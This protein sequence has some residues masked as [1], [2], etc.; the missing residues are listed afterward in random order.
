M[1]QWVQ[2]LREKIFLKILQ[3]VHRRPEDTA[4]MDPNMRVTSIGILFDGTYP[5][6][7]Q[8]LDQLV[9][10]LRQSNNQVLVLGYIDNYSIASTYPFKHFYK[11][12][13]NWLYVPKHP[14]INQF[15]RIRCDILLNLGRPDLL[16]LHYIAKQAMASF[17]VGPHYPGIEIYDVMVHAPNEHTLDGFIANVKRLLKNIQYRND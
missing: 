15:T 13:V 8:V 5:E 2:H 16:P 14:D 1:M 7:R 12:H 10:Q 3:N 17:K 11:K 9:Q 4:Y 6:D